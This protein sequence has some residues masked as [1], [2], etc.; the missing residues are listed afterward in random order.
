MRHG[1]LSNE[2]QG[3]AV[4]GRGSRRRTSRL[5]PAAAPDPM[6]VFGAVRAR[7]VR[8]LASPVLEVVIPAGTRLVSEDDEIGT[9]FLIRTGAAEISRDGVR[10]RKNVPIS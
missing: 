4:P 6:R 9:F 1:R 8:S 5:E 7:D 10:M 3:A 2:T